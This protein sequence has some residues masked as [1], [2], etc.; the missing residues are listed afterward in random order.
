MSDEEEPMTERQSIET[1]SGRI[2]YVEQGRGP[3]ALFVHGVFLNANLWDGMIDGVADVAPLHRARHPLPRADGGARRTP[4]CR[5]PARRRCWSQLLDALGVDQADVVANDSGGGIAQILAARHPE[6]VRTLTLTNCDVHDGW[7]PPAFLPT[8][9]AVLGGALRPLLESMTRPGG[10]PRRARR[11]LRAP[12]PAVGR[13]A[14][15]LPR[16]APRARTRASGTS[17]ASS[18]AMDCRQTVEVEP[19]LRRLEAP[20][21]VVWGTADVFFDVEWARWLC[22]TIPGARGRSSSCR[23]R[24]SSSPTSAAA[25][26]AGRAAPPLAGDAGRRPLGLIE[27]TLRGLADRRLDDRVR[28]ERLVHLVHPHRGV[29]ALHLDLTLGHAVDRVLHQC[30]GGMAPGGCAR[31]RWPPG[32]ARPG[33]PAGPISAV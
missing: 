18:Q 16:A 14:A 10:G 21:L 28:G 33:R 30:P 24:S 13:D 31:A 8:V 4:T 32:G 23:R 25:Q 11:R 27:K 5:S 29:E 17:S 15:R 2:A 1:A 6:R 19:L 3:V 26:L 7:P 9:Q 12:R 20:T 22:E